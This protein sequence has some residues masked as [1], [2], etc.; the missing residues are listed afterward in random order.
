MVVELLVSEKMSMP[1]SFVDKEVGW[2][3]SGVMSSELP[4]AAVGSV[5]ECA[6]WM[7][8]SDLVLVDNGLSD[9]PFLGSH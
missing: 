8:Q 7:E 4:E 1:P 9:W 6:N 2:C 5:S 3:R